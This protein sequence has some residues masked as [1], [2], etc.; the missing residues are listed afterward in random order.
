MSSLPYRAGTDP[1]GS[2]RTERPFVLVSGR[3]DD[4]R[5]MMRLMLEVWGF[6]VAEAVD[7]HECV[8]L[9]GQR[10]PCLVLV[11]AAIP[12]DDSLETVELLRGTPKTSDVPVLMIS[13]FGQEGYREAALQGGVADYLVKPVDFEHLQK[14]VM[15]LTQA[16]GRGMEE[17]VL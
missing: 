6:D 1:D 16:D 4:T 8:R 12:F 9:A 5:Y 2:D 13:G 3:H 11:D 7:C 10:K 15:N 17:K 14:L